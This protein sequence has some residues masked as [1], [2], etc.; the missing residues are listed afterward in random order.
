MRNEQEVKEA[1]RELESMLETSIPQYKRV[2]RAKI[3][4]LKWMLEEED[5][6]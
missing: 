4:V 5:V 3:E 1:L 2:F 6:F